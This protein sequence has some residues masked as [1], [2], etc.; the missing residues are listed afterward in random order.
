MRDT[1]KNRRI[2]TLFVLVVFCVFTVSVLIVLM[3]GAN[4][5]QNMTD[6]SRE[7]QD[8]RTTLAYIWTRVKSNDS[9]GTVSVGEFN[10]ISALFYDELSEDRMFRTAIYLYDGWVRELFSDIELDLPPASG[11]PIMQLD[12]LLFEEIEYGLIRVSS[13]TRSLLIYPRGSLDITR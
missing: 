2:D 6:I 7:E 12:D 8:E 9:A 3:F 11:V 13:G 10:G 4:I 1:F 5:Y